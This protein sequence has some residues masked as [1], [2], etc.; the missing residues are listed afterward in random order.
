MPNCR[1][2]PLQYQHGAKVVTMIV[3][4]I[5]T[6]TTCFAEGIRFAVNRRVILLHPP[7]VAPA[8]QHTFA[9][10]E[11]RANRDATLSHAQASLLQR[12][13]QH[14]VKISVAHQLHATRIYEAIGGPGSP[15]HNGAASLPALIRGE[16]NGIS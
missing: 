13:P 1:I 10:K 5:A 16:R 4:P 9:I 3:S 7:V 6:A 11:R 12:H 8:E 14:I 15:V 2:K